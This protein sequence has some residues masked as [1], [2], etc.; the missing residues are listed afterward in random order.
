MFHTTVR[1]NFIRN[2]NKNF[3]T[4]VLNFIRN[5]NKN[6][7]I[8][9]VNKMSFINVVQVLSFLISFASHC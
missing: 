6:F 5:L 8:Q 2:L 4:Q 3:V 1:L 7:V 9:V